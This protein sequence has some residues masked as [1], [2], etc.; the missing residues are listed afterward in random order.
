MPVEASSECNCGA[1]SS[2][3]VP[4]IADNADERGTSCT[5]A[6][7]GIIS[8]PQTLCTATKTKKTKKK[9]PLTMTG[10]S[11]AARRKMCR[12]EIPWVSTVGTRMKSCA[13]RRKSTPTRSKTCESGTRLQQ[14][15]RSTHRYREKSANTSRRSGNWNKRAA[16]DTI[17]PSSENTQSAALLSN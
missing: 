10:K 1:V 12:I 11:Q 13:Q 15:Q 17:P 16:V 7:S 3:N 4:T 14:I 5:T 2:K 6:H 9:V 8:F